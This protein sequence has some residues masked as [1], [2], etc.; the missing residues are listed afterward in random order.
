MKRYVPSLDPHLHSLLAE[1]RVPR[2]CGIR[3]AHGRSR[4]PERQ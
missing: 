4:V 3:S 2:P 1:V